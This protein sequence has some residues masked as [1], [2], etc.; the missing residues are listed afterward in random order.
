MPLQEIFLDSIPA[1]YEIL[2]ILF[3]ILILSPVFI[4]LP[5]GIRSLIKAKRNHKKSIKGYILFGVGIFWLFLLIY[6]FIFI[7]ET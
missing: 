1:F 6:F 4:G 2:S 5:L 7:V 3:L